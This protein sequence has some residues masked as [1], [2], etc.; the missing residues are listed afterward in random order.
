MMILFMQIQDSL[1][2]LFWIIYAKCA[3]GDKR[4]KMEKT[5]KNARKYSRLCT[6]DTIFCFEF[7][8]L[9]VVA[10]LVNERFIFLLLCFQY[11]REESKK[12]KEKDFFQS[13]SYDDNDV[14]EHLSR[15]KKNSV[16]SNLLD[17]YLCIID[18]SLFP[19]YNKSSSLSLGRHWNHISKKSFPF[20]LLR[21]FRW[22]V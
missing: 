13:W 21:S 17:F 19:D 11:V 6:I 10:R 9:L 3:I 4:K 20:S 12:K 7:F 1:F 14:D 2:L 8:F 18:R 15:E 16:L 22:R 5:G